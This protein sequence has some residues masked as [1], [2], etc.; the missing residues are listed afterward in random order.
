M[1]YISYPLTKIIVLCL[2]FDSPSKLSGNHV[3]KQ[4]TT[5]SP[6]KILDPVKSHNFEVGSQVTLT[7]NIVKELKR[8]G[9]DERFVFGNTLKLDAIDSISS[10][11]PPVDD[12]F[13]HHEEEPHDKNHESSI[14]A[15]IEH[16]VVA[17]PP[18]NG[19]DV[20]V[21]HIPIPRFDLDGVTDAGKQQPQQES[22]HRKSRETGARPSTGAED[23]QENSA[24]KDR[25]T[26][27]EK[28]TEKDAHTDTEELIREAEQLW[29][30]MISELR[31]RWL[32]AQLVAVV[33]RMRPCLLTFYR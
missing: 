4:P 29:I 33:H 12:S 10:S 27:K 31:G 25:D 1:K 5:N 7:S 13:E 28:E 11:H 30:K 6:P 17:H 8:P 14:R 2:S 21:D 19:D 18:N 20:S 22:E 9:W 15:E 24:D 16:L 26:D 32:C 3:G 23:G